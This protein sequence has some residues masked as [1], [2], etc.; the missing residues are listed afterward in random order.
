VVFFDPHLSSG[1]D[2][3]T[4]YERVHSIA[5]LMGRSDV[6]SVHAPLSAETRGLLGEAA[7]ATARPGLIL[8]NT[9][10][11]PIV[12]LTALEGA[13]RSGAVAGAALDVLQNEPGDLD[14]PLI[15]SW[16]AGEAWI[17]DRLIVTP[18]AAFYSPASM[19]DLRLKSVEVVH[20]FV[21]EGRLTNC[22]N[23]EYLER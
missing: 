23:R 11:G 3:S 12:E 14:H 19:V 17:K 8:I 6:V 16:R 18:H 10:R 13:L 15:D 7:F 20:A 1:V 5:E 2:L 22:V 21:A 4:G 9:A